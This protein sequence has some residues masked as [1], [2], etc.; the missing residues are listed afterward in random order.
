MRVLAV[1]SGGT[2]ATSLTANGILIGNGTSAVSAVDL[3]TKGKILVSYQENYCNH[4]IINAVIYSNIVFCFA[5]LNMP[6][7]NI[8]SPSYKG[9]VDSHNLSHASGS[10]YHLP[11]KGG[12]TAHHQRY[13]H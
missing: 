2:G 13:V 12:G 8:L 10:L 9:L 5:A 11:I 1:G 4:N 6:L 3:S 7:M